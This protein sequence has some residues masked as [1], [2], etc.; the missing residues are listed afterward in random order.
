M[1]GTSG[2]EITIPPAEST[3]TTT[4]TNAPVYY[5]DV[6]KV[7]CPGCTTFA[8]DIL[9]V[10]TVLLANGNYYNIGDGFVYRVNFGTGAGAPVVDLSVSATAGNDCGA[11]CAL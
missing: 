1:A 10:S 2:S 11:T 6:D 9:A 8:A 4:T 5:Y 3:T 7:N